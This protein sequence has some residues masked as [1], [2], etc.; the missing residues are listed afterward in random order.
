MKKFIFLFL[1]ISVLQS[2]FFDLDAKTSSNIS[3]KLDKKVVLSTQKITLK[4]YSD[5]FNPSIIQ[6]DFGYILTFRY[7]P[8]RRWDVISYLGIVKLNTA[9][10]PISTPQIID[11]SFRNS[12]IQAQTEDPRIFSLNGKLYIIYNDNREFEYL[13][14]EVRRDMFIAELHENS[15]SF[16]LGPP[17]KLIHEDKYSSVLSQKNWVPFEWNGLLLLGYSVSRMKY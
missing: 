4:E 3:N 2:Y 6:T 17:L 14:A 5:A 8:D 7:C 10:K 9:F 1:A 13:T 16:F 11:I 12:D 15:G